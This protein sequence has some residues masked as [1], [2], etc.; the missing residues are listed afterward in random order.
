MIGKLNKVI[1]ICLFFLFL[2]GM[3]HSYAQE[4]KQ[5]KKI[6]IIHSDEQFIPANSSIDSTIVSEL[7]ASSDFRFII[8][9]QYLDANRFDTKEVIQINRNLFDA[10]Y[11]SLKPD[12]I[13]TV[14]YKAFEFI[15]KDTNG[16]YD[17]TPIVFCMVPEGQID[18]LKLGKNIT[19]NYMNIDAF[20]TAELI[21]KIHPKTKEIV[22]I[23]GN[24]SA[25]SSK[26]EG[27][28][29]ALKPLNSRVKVTFLK[30]L[31]IE[32]ISEKLSKL[33]NDTVVIYGSLFQDSQGKTYIPREALKR[34]NLKTRVPIYGL[35]YSN[36]DY[37]LVGGNLFEFAEV[38]KDA[39]RKSIE[40]LK[41]QTPSNLPILKV[42]NKNYYDWNE[43]NRWKIS[44]Q[45]LPKPY[46]LINKNLTLWDKYKLQ[47]SGVL[48][49]IFMQTGF[50]LFLIHQLQRRRRAEKQILQLNE[51][52][53]DLVIRRTD[54]LHEIQK[55]VFIVEKQEGINHLIQ[56][57]LHRINTP[58]GNAINFI[59]LLKRDIAQTDIDSLKEG[60]S[61]DWQGILNH[62]QSNQSSIRETMESL[63]NLLDVDSTEPV[64]A[65]NLADEI[66]LILYDR[67][68]STTLKNDFPVVLV[69]YPEK[70][71]S[72]Q[73]NNFKK[74]VYSLVEFAQNSH[75]KTKDA[76]AA[77]LIFDLVEQ[78]LILLY[79]DVLLED[80]FDLEKIFTPYGYN[81]FKSD[82]FGL[83][84]AVFYNCV[85]L[86][87]NGDV[88][89][90]ED[91]EGSYKRIIRA[92]FE[93]GND[94]RK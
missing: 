33:P 6:L 56:N 81:A 66:Q 76:K 1:G 4:E 72:L 89:I 46:T 57:L 38:A 7:N 49:L 35:F 65:V 60:L 44:E 54:E 21:M 17:N 30:N 8:F 78:K 82:G 26:E 52:L 5:I 29:I 62:L 48:L 85:T 13:I 47:I 45:Q 25:D 31:S 9:S 51:G 36:L 55:K 37:G 87:L 88:E 79:K 69:C 50:V 42:E 18:V 41:G 64:V 22:V 32:G 91:A 90:V 24:G 63:K 14:D 40:I 3:K 92:S 73:L 86:G 39:A 93:L 74:A 67:H 20:K 10:K 77:E 53:E 84:L 71:V 94:V 34:I 75:S 12:L 61:N 19:G 58:L 11:S 15:Q 28:I 2:F 16:I 68:E 59:D 83:E 70:V 43:L 27:V 80:V 23:F